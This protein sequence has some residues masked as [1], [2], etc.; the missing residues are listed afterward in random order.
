MEPAENPFST[1]RIR[2]GAI[3]YRFFRG[4]G[5]VESVY[6]K[7]MSIGP[8]AQ[9]RGDHGSGKSTLLAVFE[10]RFAADGFTV[11][12]HIMADPRRDARTLLADDGWNSKTVVVV[13]GFERLSWWERTRLAFKRWFTGARLLITT[14]VDQGWPE[15]CRLE[16]D[17]SDVVELARLL[18]SDH[19]VLVTDDD[20]RRCFRKHQGNVRE[21]LFEMFDI[22]QLR[23]RAGSQPNRD[24]KSKS[25]P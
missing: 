8:K 14:H 25:E 20:A 9:I 15:V 6:E 19:A 13:D 1:R 23:Q 4:Q 5:S 7:W 16:P 2:P 24:T 21:A 12:T 22:Y 10:S 17:E 3:P 18:Q 11:R